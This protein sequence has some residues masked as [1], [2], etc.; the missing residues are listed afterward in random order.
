MEL[1][2]SRIVI[3]PTGPPPAEMFR[4]GIDTTAEEDASEEENDDDDDKEAD[5]ELDNE[6]N[7]STSDGTLDS[8]DLVSGTSYLCFLQD[9]TSLQPHTP[10][11]ERIK[12]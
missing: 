8:D 6:P 10:S 11:L 12:P 7:A 9:L 3:Q 5:P 4:Q 2:P 1:Y